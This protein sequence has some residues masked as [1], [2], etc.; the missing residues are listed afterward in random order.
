LSNARKL[1]GPAGGVIDKEIQKT[2]ASMEESIAPAPKPGDPAPYLILPKLPLA[3]EKLRSELRR[4][5]SMAKIDYKKGQVSGA[6][7]HGGEDLTQT[8]SEAYRM[9]CSS[10]P[11]HPDLFPGIRKMEAEVVK[12]VVDLFHGGERGCGSITSGGT[13]SILMACKA[14]RE[15]GAERGITDPEMYIDLFFHSN[16]FSYTLFFVQKF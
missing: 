3:A 16:L 8:I 1:P 7:Y 12:M 6:V 10:N 11:L 5:Q 9:F 14:Y 13:E 4:Y 2:L 15:M